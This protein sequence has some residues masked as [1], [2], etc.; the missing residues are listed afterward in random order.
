MK[1]EVRNLW[2]NIRLNQAEYDR[3]NLL[4]N[5]S[6]CQQLSQYARL[7]ILQKPVTVYHR[8]QSLDE[9]QSELI[10]LKNELAAIGNN[11][12]QVVHKLHMLDTWPEV[13]AWLAIN[14]AGKKNFMLKMDEI[15]KRMNEVYELWSQK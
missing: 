5:K 7:M 15:V 6:T 11:Y 10:K 2:L 8:N 13:K 9:F 12:N 1:K 3:L 4:F 14:E